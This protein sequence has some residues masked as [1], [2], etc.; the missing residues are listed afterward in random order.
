MFELL[1]PV[2]ACEQLG[3]RI[4]ALRL[5]RNVSQR[6]LAGMTGSSLSSIRRLEASGQG[7]LELVVR[8]AQSLNATAQLDALFVQPQDS[9]ARMEAQAQG[10]QRARRAAAPVGLD[11]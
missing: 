2:T 8:V 7:S 9:I 4:R 11:G 5:A 3:S 6:E 1:S 10:R